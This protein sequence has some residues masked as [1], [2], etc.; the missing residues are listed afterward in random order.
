M[1]STTSTK[2][3]TNMHTL[4]LLLL[5]FFTIVHAAPVP[6]DMAMR[7]YKWADD[8]TEKKIDKVR[9]TLEATKTSVLRDVDGSVA[10]ESAAP[11]PDSDNEM[12]R[13]AAKY[14]KNNQKRQKKKMN[15]AEKV[16]KEDDE[17][18]FPAEA[19]VYVQDRGLV[20]MSRLNVGDMVEV[21]PGRFS[22]VLLFSHRNAHAVSTMIRIDIGR[23]TSRTS[24]TLSRGHYLYRS[25]G[26]LIS[27]FQVRVGDALASGT[28]QSIT[29]MR[30]TGLFAPHTSTGTLLV[31]SAGESS[32]VLASAYTTTVHPNAAHAAI[33]PLR[34][35]HAVFGVKVPA[36][37]ALLDLYHIVAA[38]LRTT[39]RSDYAQTRRATASVQLA[40]AY[41]AVRRAFTSA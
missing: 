30:S 34:A 27:A 23:G 12:T 31:R 5:T 13:R 21:A 9:Q 6:L 35:L 16:K 10:E 24:V 2:M 25:D 19:L 28:V 26:E 15:K 14:E 32:A 17:S 11:T 40:I 20:N 22:P 37:S 3:P 1:A 36:A 18:C 4:T 7:V 41:I 38:H 8:V 29:L 39:L 33:T